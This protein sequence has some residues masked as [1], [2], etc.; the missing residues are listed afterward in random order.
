MAMQ[1]QLGQAMPIG[2]L[3]T[4]TSLKQYLTDQV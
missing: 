3:H 1:N 2:G 4:T